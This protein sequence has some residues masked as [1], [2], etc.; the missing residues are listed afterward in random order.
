[1]RYVVRSS[2]LF[3]GRDSQ[4]PLSFFT[5]CVQVLN[6]R[7]YAHSFSACVAAG[8]FLVFTLYLEIRLIWA[9]FSEV[10]RQTNAHPESV[11]LLSRCAKTRCFPAGSFSSQDKRYF[12]AVACP[13][14]LFLV[15]TN[16]L[17]FS[18]CRAGISTTYLG[19]LV[20]ER[21]ELGKPLVLRPET[22]FTVQDNACFPIGH[23]PRSCLEFTKG[24]RVLFFF[25]RLHA[26]KRSFLVSTRCVSAPSSHPAVVALLLY[27]VVYAASSYSLQV[28][29]CS[30]LFSEHLR[31]FMWTFPLP[32]VS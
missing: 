11:F 5:R 21:G 29:P 16:S 19:V 6:C 13:L 24:P 1:M 25:Q 14:F 27:A 4:R 23:S 10:T 31:V 8:H 18:R 22:T 15:G 17:K 2:L 9:R 7:V 26:W 30:C 12:P 20:L 32:Q 28:S 3:S